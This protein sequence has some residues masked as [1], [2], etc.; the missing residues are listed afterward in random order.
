MNLK[1]RELIIQ[2]LNALGVHKDA[3]NKPLDELDYLA[4][5]YL[6]AAKL[7]VLE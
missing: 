2:Q 3:D 7:A 5:K 1:Q 4:L 6:L